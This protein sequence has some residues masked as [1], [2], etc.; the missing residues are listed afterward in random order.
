MSSPLAASCD[1][2]AA[3]HSVRR[4]LLFGVGP[5][6]D[7]SGDGAGAGDS[8]LPY[9]STAH[10]NLYCFLASP[11][12]HVFLCSP[13]PRAWLFMLGSSS[14][15]P[16]SRPQP[17]PPWSNQADH[18]GAAVSRRGRGDGRGGER[19]PR[20]RRRAAFG[21]QPAGFRQG[22]PAAG[23]A[24]LARRLRRLFARPPGGGRRG[25]AAAGGARCGEDHQ[26]PARHAAAHLRGAAVRRAGGG[27]RHGRA[28]IAGQ[29]IGLVEE[30][31]V[32]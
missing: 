29:Q 3:R 4:G 15:L 8:H 5:V 28:V 26:L 6:H 24:A 1:C 13:P 10:L 27:R 11:Y 7:A 32:V 16:P 2:P 17:L 30:R 25:L 12:L 22:S 19:L 31:G 14:R 9:F 18:S 21:A 20:P 23:G